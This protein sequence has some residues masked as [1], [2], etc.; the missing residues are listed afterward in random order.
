MNTSKKGQSPKLGNPRKAAPRQE[1]RC[2]V[3][4]PLSLEGVLSRGREESTVVTRNMSASGILFETHDPLKVGQG[5]DFAIRMP[6]DILGSSGDVM[7]RCS[8]RVVRCSISQGQYQAAATIDDY[9]FAE[10]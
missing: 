10:Q 4:F 6:G 1:V 9:K 8:G 2:A 7:V 3:R 5:I